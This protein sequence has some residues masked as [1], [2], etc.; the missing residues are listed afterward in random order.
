MVWPDLHRSEA[1][2]TGAEAAMEPVRAMATERG[3]P[4]EI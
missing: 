1:L 2:P 4:A 3:F